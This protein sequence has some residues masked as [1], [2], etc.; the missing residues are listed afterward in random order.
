[1]AILP[2]GIIICTK[3]SNEIRLISDYDISLICN[4]DLNKL[5]NKAIKIRSERS[6]ML[7]HLSKNEIINKQKVFNKSYNGIH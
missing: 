4:I 7:N 5:V 2:Y 1:M 3:V 6:T